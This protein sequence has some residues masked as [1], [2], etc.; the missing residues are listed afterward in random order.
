MRLHASIRPPEWASAHLEA[1]LRPEFAH[2]GQISWIPAAH[3]R[4]HLAGFG[5]VTQSDGHRLA[6]KL[7]A[8][9]VEFDAPTLRLSGVVALPEDG[10]D[11]VWV[12]VT[13]DRDI[14]AGLAAALPDWVR[15]FGFMIDRRS[16]R[17]RIQLGKVTA[18]TTA[19]YLERLVARLGSY[20]GDPWTADGVTLGHEEP[21]STEREPRFD[22]HRLA[23]FGAGE[24]E[25]LRSGEASP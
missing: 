6:D 2:A 10:D 18:S 15:E 3:W 19:P 9:V 12:T 13:G 17:P 21:G 25:P 5:N 1:A 4:L 23:Q 24:S 22:V 14:V 20:H 7:T 8:H 16:Y 11:S